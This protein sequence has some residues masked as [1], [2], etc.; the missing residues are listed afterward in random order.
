MSILL[1]MHLLYRRLQ[2]YI[3]MYVA[4]TCFICMCIYLVVYVCDDTHTYV[5]YGMSTISIYNVCMHT[6]IE[7]LYVCIHLSCI[8]IYIHL[9]DI[10]IVCRYVLY[11]YLDTPI[12]SP[13]MFS[14][15]MSTWLWMLYIDIHPM[16]CLCT[17]FDLCCIMY[18]NA[19]HKFSL[20]LI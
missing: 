8:F 2:V 3:I 1:C 10:I 20:M 17:L 15:R 14:I 4:Y 7:S 12:L 5:I 19:Y 9:D 18:N 11:M 13:C 16:N 6:H